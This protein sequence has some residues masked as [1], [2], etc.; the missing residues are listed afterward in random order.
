MTETYQN[1]VSAG[2][3]AIP[4]TGVDAPASKHQYHSSKHCTARHKCTKS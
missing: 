4:N 3:C 2:E 1:E